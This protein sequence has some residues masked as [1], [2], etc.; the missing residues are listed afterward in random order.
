MEKAEGKKRWWVVLV[1]YFLIAFEIFYMVSPFALYYYSVYGKGLDLL[2]SSLVTKWLASFFLPHIVVETKSHWLDM[3]NYIGGILAAAGFLVFLCGAAQIYYHKFTGRGAV[4][5]GIYNHIRHPQYAALA[6]SGF[7]MLLLWPR[8]LVLITYTAMLFAYYFLARA[9]ERECLAK[10][11]E[12]Y[13]DY[14]GRTGMFLP[15]RINLP[16]RLRSFPKSGALRYLSLAA[17]FLTVTAAGIGAANW[18]KN[19]ALDNMYIL[20]ARDSAYISLSEVESGQ[21]RRI[22]DLALSDESVRSRVIK[23]GPDSR[24]ISYVLPADWYV[25]EIPMNDIEGRG[26][27]SPGGYNR[28]LYKIVF[29]RTELNT[30]E[31]VQGK[32]IILRASGLTPLVEV[33]VDLESNKVTEIKDTPERIRYENVPTPVF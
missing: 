18:Q 9:E 17:V 6:V 4:T 22:T 29:T 1:F 15:V 3:H 11:G 32:E 28:S 24:F 20:Y 10:F 33:T 7:G 19:Y 8:Y 14:K 5:G 2:N 23:K 27:Y 12:S 21:L 30:Q 25:A 31:D 13:N 26:H 16:D